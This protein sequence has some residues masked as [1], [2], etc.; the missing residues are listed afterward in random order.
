M[1]N[2]IKMRRV[3]NK[4]QEV[5]QNKVDMSDLTMPNDNHFLT[6]T[7]AGLALMM[8]SGLD[9]DSSCSHIT[10]NYHDMGIDSIYLDESQK[11]LFLV[12]SKWRNDG[13]GGV[14]QSEMHTFADGVSRIIDMDLDGANQKIIAERDN[15][16][17]ALTSFGYQ[18]Q[19]VYIHTGDQK[20]NDYA[21]RP[22]KILLDHTND[23]DNEI[24][25]FDEITLN[26]IY[27]YFAK[28]QGPEE[29]SL[30]DV[31][32]SNWGKISEPYSAYYGTISAATIGEWYQE[33]GNLLFAKNIRYYKGNTSVNDGMEQVLL[34]EPENFIFYNN[35]IKILCKS[36]KRK[37]KNATTNETG[38]FMLE[39][40]SLVNGAQ[41]TGTIGH[42]YLNHK[43]QTVKARVMIQIIDLSQA[44]D[45]AAARIT[46]LSNT[47]NRIENRDFASMDPVQEKIR[48]DLSFAHFSYLYKS[49]DDMTDPS[50][51][52][53]FDEAIIAMACLNSDIS[54]SATA[55]RN[56]GAL[57]E[58]ITKPPY[59]VLI[60]A[61]INTNE[62]LN[63]VMIVRYVD[64]E[65]R[66]RKQELSGKERLVT[67]HGNRFIA[68][69]V[70]QQLK[71]DVNF[72]DKPLY[73][74]QLQNRTYKLVDSL[75]KPITDSIKEIFPDSY[76]A[77]IFKNI[78]K[79]KDIY[80]K[81]K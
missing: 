40:V 10:D 61:G 81:V 50:C 11:M 48:Q 52:L 32:I 67:I 2:D 19:A 33:Y 28:G 64:K 54:Y 4:L 1:A 14:S 76:P 5:F 13:K 25:K 79:C 66:K 78:T 55:K 41:T 36:V 18:I 72:S 47:Q 68:Y 58:D 9:V 26:D 29:I 16:E 8:K 62:L 6:R 80:E 56:I 57:S 39:G 24:L 71:K 23:E 27:S 31:M 3:T 22:M 60:N 63:S 21:F 75:I 37:L 49:G 73:G 65:L 53:T 30:D 7:L 17:E 20:V 51:Q 77:N 74:E 15:I 46:K 12:Q 69:C 59:K 34:H 45:E 44:T 42:V 43:E 35:G 38:L 70:L